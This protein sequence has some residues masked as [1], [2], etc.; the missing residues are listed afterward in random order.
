MKVMYKNDGEYVDYSLNGS[1]LSFRENELTLDLAEYERDR[2]V[3]VTVSEDSDGKLVMGVS[4]WYIAEIDIP[5]I[6]S[7][8]EKTG[9]ADD[10]GFPVL[11]RVYAPFSADNVT[12]ILWA[13]K[14]GGH[15]V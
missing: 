14:G 8:V 3:C 4:Q 2:P 15:D 1:I 6:R 13:I 5:A 7:I 11:R 12:L 9:I 10:F